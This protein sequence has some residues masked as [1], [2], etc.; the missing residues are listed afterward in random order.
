MTDETKP[1]V[2]FYHLERTTLERVLPGLLEKSLE[3]GWRAVV[4]ASSK[5]RIEAL[6]TVLWSYREDSFL[7]HGGANDEHAGLHPIVL[8]A[9]D[10]NPNGA[11]IRFFVDGAESGDLSGYERAVYL[12][13]GRDEDAVSQAREQWKK[14]QAAGYDAT[15]WQQSESGKWE[16]KA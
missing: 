12:F 5:E 16:R 4:Q 7:P 14:V 10:V 13:D 8:T 2:L 6:D 11:N 9:E 15:Y 1:E 3:R